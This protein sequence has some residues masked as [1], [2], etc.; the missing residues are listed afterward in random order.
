MYF[1][2]S[3]NTN[4]PVVCNIPH[5][6]TKVPSEFQDDYALSFEEVRQE[7]FSMADL[8]TEELFEELVRVSSCVQST[9]ARI[10]VDIERFPDEKE[11]PMSTVGMSAFY[12]LTRTG[13]L[14][15]NISDERKVVLQKIYDEYHTMFTEVVATSLATHN[16]AIIVDCHSFPSVPRQY[17]LD[18]ET[19]R[20]DIC[21]GVDSYHTPQK[22]ID[23]LRTNF[24]KE[25]YS[26]KINSPFSGTIV[27]LSFYKKESRVL[28]VMIEVNRSLYM[29]EET[30]QKLK[31]FSTT[32]KHISRCVLQGL[33]EFYSQYGL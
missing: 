22:L 19:D 15:R 11:E 17:E 21:L 5:S 32:S 29:N 24:E 23:I 30:C 8:Y 27:P 2:V 16:T 1:E 26:V 31:T 25:G 6:S 20:P 7:A 10:V 12:T 14:L 13:K 33:N 3:K 18:Q 28:S 4:S 9:L